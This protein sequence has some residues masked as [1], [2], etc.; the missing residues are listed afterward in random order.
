MV[1]VAAWE[2]FERCNGTTKTLSNCLKDC[3]EFKTQYRTEV[4]PFKFDSMAAN[5]SN[6]G[7]KRKNTATT[8][9]TVPEKKVKS[10]MLKK[11]LQ[12]SGKSGGGG[13]ANVPLPKR[14]ES[15]TFK[16]HENQEIDLTKDHLRIFLSNL[17]YRYDSH[18]LGSKK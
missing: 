6:R 17:D 15:A 10:E 18:L 1:I 3:A 8:K 16:E 9:S 5:K 4:S 11:D 13:S 14:V 2:R 7:S 12:P